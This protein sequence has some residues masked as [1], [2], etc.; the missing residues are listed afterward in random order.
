MGPIDITGCLKK[1]GR[2]RSKNFLPVFGNT[3]KSTVAKTANMVF[4]NKSILNS[5]N[6]YLLARILL[7][8]HIFHLFIDLLCIDFFSSSYL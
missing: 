7:R 4:E 1:A 5:S 6:E 3:E 8:F 2:L